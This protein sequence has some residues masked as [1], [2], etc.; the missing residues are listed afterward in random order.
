MTLCTAPEKP[1]KAETPLLKLK[2]GTVVSVFDLQPAA[3][4]ML[5]STGLLKLLSK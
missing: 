4:K 3:F 1:S 5:D 2:K